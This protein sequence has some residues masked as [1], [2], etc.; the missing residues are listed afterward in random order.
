MKKIVGGKRYDT[1][2]ATLVGE[3]VYGKYGNRGDLE[4]IQEGL[5]RTK[6]GNYFVAGVGGPRTRYA[7]SIS[8]NYWG[9]S[10]DIYPLSPEEALE[11]AQAYLEEYEIEKEFG[12]Q[13]EDA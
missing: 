6:T 12:S 11:W 9:G 10:E 4:R 13:I 7:V 1:D 3:Y 2:T 5:Y 8:Q